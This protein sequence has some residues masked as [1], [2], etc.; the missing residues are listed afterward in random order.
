MRY[1]DNTGAGLRRLARLAASTTFACVT[2]LG[3][4]VAQ[5]TTLSDTPGDILPSYTGPAAP[6]L[7]VTSVTALFDGVN[8]R[9]SAT[10]NGDIGTT[11]NGIY[12]WGVDRGAGTDLLAH[13]TSLTDTTTPV[14]QGVNFDAFI[15]L[16]TTGA[17]GLVVRL[18]PADPLTPLDPVHPTGANALP[19]AYVSF[20]GRTI[21]AIVPLSM[22][23]SQGFDVADYGFN[24]WPRINDISSNVHV[25]DFA[26]D[27]TTF[28]ATAVPEPASWALMISGFG[29]LGTALRR[30]RLLPA[31]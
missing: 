16:N 19:A 6:D 29:L 13:P 4:T 27:H 12:V 8:F 23:P 17:D 9:L 30:R 28:K 31:T 3:A 11:P 2:V 5:A 1:F 15:V 26:P 14:G 25:T 24:M 20:S 21:N 22:L 10:M 18:G 7:D